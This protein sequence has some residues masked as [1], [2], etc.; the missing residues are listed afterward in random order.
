MPKIKVNDIELHYKTQGEGEPLVFLHGFS[1]SHK[2]W[3]PWIPTYQ[4]GFKMI[5]IDMR[6][7]GASTNPS[8]K[9]THRQSAK[10]IYTLLDKLDIKQFKA[11]G[12][13]SGAMTLLHM[14]TQQ[15]TRPQSMVLC[16]ATHY[17]PKVNREMQSKVLDKEYDERWMTRAHLHEKGA[18]QITQL[19]HQFHKM[20]DSYTD[21]NF[22]PPYLSTIQAKTLIV[23]GDRDPY[24][25]INIPVEL[26]TSIPD[27]SLWI[28]P[29]T[30]H[31]VAYPAPPHLIEKTFD[32]LKT[33]WIST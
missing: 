25:P 10:D 16:S 12:Y 22:T 3:E 31:E 9:F 14:A 32:F 18:E 2:M 5:L 29:N 7:H 13:S 23:H 6:G 27:S 28:M 17:F 15:P 33:G 11:I 24:F 4:K 20:K 26:Y 1:A 21:M 8:N 30:G 19:R